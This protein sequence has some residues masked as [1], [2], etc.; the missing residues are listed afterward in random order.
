VRNEIVHV[1]SAAV[2]RFPNPG[3][4][5]SRPRATSD[6]SAL[7]EAVNAYGDA[8]RRTFN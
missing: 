5:R 3:E 1:H 8:G 6:Y 7:P 2:L 4:E